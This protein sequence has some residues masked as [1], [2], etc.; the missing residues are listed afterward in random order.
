MYRMAFKIFSFTHF[1]DAIMPTDVTQSVDESDTEKTKT[2]TAVDSSKESEPTLA[3]DD[4]FEVTTEQNDM[5]TT[6][7]DLS[8]EYEIVEDATCED[9]EWVESDETWV[10]INSPYSTVRVVYRSYFIRKL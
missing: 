6:P 5:R 9:G 3:S 4:A 10:S 8:D 1:P 2:T 7:P